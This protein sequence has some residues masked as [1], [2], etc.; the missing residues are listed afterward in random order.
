NKRRFIP[1]HYISSV[2]IDIYQS[3]KSCK[4]ISKALG[5]QE[6]GT[7]VNLPRSRRPNKIILRVHQRLIQEV[8]KELRTTSKKL[9]VHGRLVS[10]IFTFLENILWTEDM[11]VVKNKQHL[12][13][14]TSSKHGGCSVMIWGCFLHSMVLSQRLLTAGRNKRCRVTG[15]EGTSH[16]GH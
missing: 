4:A 10:H 7:A 2:F 9:L 3:G 13:K 6:A 14:R 12:I 16:T 8:T 5:L 1:V 15:L 11:K